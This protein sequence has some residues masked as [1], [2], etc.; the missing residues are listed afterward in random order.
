MSETLPGTLR[1]C[2]AIIAYALNTIFWC[3][4]LFIVV[5]AK[6]LVPIGAW[7]RRCGRVLNGIAHHPE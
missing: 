1:G 7:R 6:A 2:L 5:A 3:T 4:P